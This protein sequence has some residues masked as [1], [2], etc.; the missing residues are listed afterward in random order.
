MV[1]GFSADGF[2]DSVLIRLSGD[3]F[4]MLEPV[5]MGVDVLL[6]FISICPHS[7]M[8]TVRGKRIFQPSFVPPEFV[9]GVI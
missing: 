6:I 1:A 4:P 3:S 2:T 9:V 5:C 7:R 8:N